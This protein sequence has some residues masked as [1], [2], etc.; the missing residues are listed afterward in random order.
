MTK[1]TKG[2]K[3]GFISC[4]W[5]QRGKEFL[6]LMVENHHTKQ[7]WPL[8]QQVENLLVST[9]ISKKQ[10]ES[11]LGMAKGFETSKTSPNA[12]LPLRRPHLLILPKQFHQNPNI[13]DYRGHF[14]SNHHRLYPGIGSQKSP[15]S[16]ELLL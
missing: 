8:K 13:K 16:C 14:Y 6:S 10:R 15:F 1:A 12:T 11:T 4:L 3:E 2:R 7:A 9:T 5:F